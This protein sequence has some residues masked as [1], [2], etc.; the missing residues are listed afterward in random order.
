MGFHASEEIDIDE[1]VEDTEFEEDEEYISPVKTS[2]ERFYSPHSRSTSDPFTRPSGAFVRRHTT[3]ALP[4]IPAQTPVYNLPG[5]PSLNGVITELP[6]D[7]VQRFWDAFC[8]FQ[9]D[10][11]A[12]VRESRYERYE[13]HCRAFWS[14]Q[15]PQL[16]SHPLISGMISDA[17]AVSYDVSGP[18][19]TPLTS[20]SH[21]HSHG[22]AHRSASWWGRS[23]PPRGAAR[24]HHGGLL[25]S[26]AQ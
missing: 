15:S 3:S 19:S 25:P 17:M 4:S 13:S 8:R 12:Y 18:S 7:A 5:F 1:D 9:E 11:S 26:A 20:E 23:S 10:L 14:S 22:Q 21:V 24:V 2:P 6:H 16:V